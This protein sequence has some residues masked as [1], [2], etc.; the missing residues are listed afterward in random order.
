MPDKLMDLL[1]KMGDRVFTEAG[2]LALILFWFC[3]YLLLDNRS[4]RR[5][6]RT[7]NDKIFTMG[8]QQVTVNSESNAVMGK[9]GETVGALFSFIT[10]KRE[11]KE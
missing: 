7:L 5:E 2:I 1:D 3:I 10:T 8:M 11:P 4:Y 6:N 9:L